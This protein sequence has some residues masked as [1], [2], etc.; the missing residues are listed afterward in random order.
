MLH[1]KLINSLVC[2]PRQAVA[3][4]DQRHPG[5]GPEPGHP[6]EVCPGGGA[7]EGGPGAGG[8]ALELPAVPHGPRQRRVVLPT[9]RVRPLPLPRTLTHPATSGAAPLWNKSSAP[10]FWSI[11]KSRLFKR[12]F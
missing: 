1:S 2:V 4:R 6:G 8:Q 3:A 5:P 9:H 12:L 10:L 11:L 7:A